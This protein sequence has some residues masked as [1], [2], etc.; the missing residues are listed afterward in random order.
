MSFKPYLF[1]TSTYPNTTHVNPLAISFHKPDI[2]FSNYDYIILTSKQAVNALRQYKYT[3]YKEKSALCIS[4]ATAQSFIDSNG[5]VLEVGRGY[6]AN[7]SEIIA[8][9]P[10]EVKWLYLRAKEVASD[11]ATVS[12]NAGYTVDEAIVYE[13][14]CSNEIQIVKVAENDI[15]I[16]T[17]PSSVKCFLKYHELKE[18]HR[19]VVI[20]KTTAKAIPSYINP[21]IADEPSIQSCLKIINSL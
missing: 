2:N 6:G 4:N 10:K 14:R 9:Y 20:G 18:K 19:V 8:K 11:F 13:S 16:F 21:I 1:S 17:S 5:T 7:L 12:K 15:L 3:E